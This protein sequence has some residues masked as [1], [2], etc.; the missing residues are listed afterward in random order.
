MA[1]KR[2]PRIK[3]C[4]VL[5][6]PSTP[7]EQAA[8]DKKFAETLAIG[9]YRSLSQQEFEALITALRKAIKNNTREQ[10][11]QMKVSAL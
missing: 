4:I 8:Y 11:P 3:S 9:L 6:P 5:N 10:K 2:E 7:E 1:R